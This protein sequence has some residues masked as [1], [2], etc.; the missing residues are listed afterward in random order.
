MTEISELRD[1]D[2][3]RQCDAE[4]SR[5]LLRLSG[6]PG[7]KVTKKVVVTK[8]VLDALKNQMNVAADLLGQDVYGVLDWGPD[9]Q[10]LLRGVPIACE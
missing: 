9:Y 10:L 2:N 3:A 6:L 4:D 5:K 1:Q 8:G 7:W